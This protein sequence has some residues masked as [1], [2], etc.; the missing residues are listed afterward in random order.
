MFFL[1][2]LTKSSQVTRL[3]R[4]PWDSSDSD[5]TDSDSNDSDSD[6]NGSTSSAIESNCCHR[7]VTNHQAGQG[8]PTVTIGI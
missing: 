6:S 8:N 7:V 2:A 3:A 4:A 5:S 1:T